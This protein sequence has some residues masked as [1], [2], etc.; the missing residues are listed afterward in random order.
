MATHQA[1][2]VTGQAILGLLAS[3]CPPQFAGAQFELY[4]PSNFL[5]PI[6]EGISLYLYRVTV[7]TA[8]RNLPV[9]TNSD[10]KRFKPSLPV[11]LYYMLTP[12][13]K[14]AAKQQRLLGWSMRVLEDA[15]TLH[16]NLLN[17]YGEADTFRSNESV[18]LVCE[19]IALQDMINI[20]DV[21]KPHQQLSVTY[22]AR[23]I[24]IDSEIGLAEMPLVGARGTDA[25]AVF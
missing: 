9:R 24:T 17:R 25:G 13:A 19:P 1:I 22:V 16:A 15:N 6:E 20:W 14:T 3:E 12:W 4:Q 21:F 8:R 5:N 18:E 7:N 10:K 11:D 23:M 2:A